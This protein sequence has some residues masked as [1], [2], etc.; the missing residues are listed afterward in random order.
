MHAKEHLSSGG[1]HYQ[2]G[3]NGK[4]RETNHEKNEMAGQLHEWTHSTIKGK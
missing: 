4:R 3:V 2:H 1:Q